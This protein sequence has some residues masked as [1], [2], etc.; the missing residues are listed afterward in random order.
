[1]FSEFILYG[2]VFMY[3][4]LAGFVDFMIKSQLL[5]GLDDTEKYERIM[6]LTIKRL[7]PNKQKDRHTHKQTK[8]KKNT[9]KTY[10]LRK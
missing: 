6:Y 7:S 8:Q 4:S 9:M 5:F 10:K 2:M 1:M 3:G